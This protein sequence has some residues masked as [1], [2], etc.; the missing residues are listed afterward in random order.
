MTAPQHYSRSLQESLH[1]ASTMASSEGH[2]TFGVAHLVLALLHESIPSGLR[3]IITSMHKDLTYVME[4]FD[5]YRELY[6]SDGEG[7][8]TDNPWGADSEVLHL[9][10]E[11]ERS[12]IKLGQDELDGLCLLL[13]VVR[14]GAI[15]SDSQLQ[16]LELTEEELLGFFESSESIL[17]SDK[18]SQLLVAYPFVRVS[19]SEET[20][21]CYNIRGRDKELRQMEET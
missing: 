8:D 5:T 18:L 12:K 15:Y 10:E 4:W 19:S 1:F 6:V 2:S 3:E 9:L 11:A 14:K 20:S 13:A 17:P 21:L 7:H 16:S